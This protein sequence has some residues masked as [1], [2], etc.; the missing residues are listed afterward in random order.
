MHT[1]LARPYD[2][3]FLLLALEGRNAGLGT[4]WRRCRFLR[5]WARRGHP[6]REVSLRSRPTL[7][8]SRGSA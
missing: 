6:L 3:L 1:T 8:S 2:R 5:E 4:T 7:C